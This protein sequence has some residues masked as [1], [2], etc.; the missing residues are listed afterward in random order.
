MTGAAW[1][2]GWRGVLLAVALVVPAHAQSSAGLATSFA[3]DEWLRA[4]T[5]I[6]L[7]IAAVPEAGDA[8]RI[9]L[10]IGGVDV[11]A[12]VTQNGRRI[13]YDPRILPLPAGESEIVAYGVASSGEWQ[14]LGRAGL[15]V[16]SAA[17]FERAA[18]DPHLSLDMASQLA[19]GHNTG[20]LAPSRATF[21][22]YSLQ[23]GLQTEHVRA[24]WSLRSQLNLHGV[25]NRTQALRF[26]EQAEAAPRLDLA[27]YLVVGAA[28]RSNISVGHV[29]TPSQRNLADGQARR[30]VRWDMRLAGMSAGLVASNATSVVGWANPLGLARDR[31]R[32]LLGRFGMDAL[33]GIP[34][35]VRLGGTLVHGSALPLSGY[36]GGGVLGAERSRGAGIDFEASD[37]SGRVRLSSSYAWSR[38]ED[39]GDPELVQGLELVPIGRTTRSARHLEVG[40]D[41][42][43]DLRLSGS[44]SG[45]LSATMRHERIDPLYRSVATFVQGD[46]E[47][48]ALDVTG[49][50]GA[51]NA[52]YSYGRSRDNLEAIP[53]VLTTLTRAQQAGV[54]LPFGALFGAAGSRWLPQL[55]WGHH[56]FHQFG[57]SV[58]VDGDF[59]ETHVPDQITTIRTASAQWSLGRLSGGYQ[60]EHST[61]DNRQ[62]GREDADFTRTAHTVAAAVQ[63]ATRLELGADAGFEEAL[64]HE[65][66][67]RS[68]VRR[69][70]VTGSLVLW[71]NARIAAAGSR[72][73]S[74]DP[75][76]EGASR[77]IDQ[78]RLE[79][80]QGVTLRRRG[81]G[82]SFRGQLFL[83]YGRQSGDLFGPAA[84][85]RPANWT[86]NSGVNLRLF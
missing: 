49:R 26:G 24:R 29:G 4:G 63:L 51:L 45:A 71:S 43:R 80:T 68:D 58:P 83:R 52:H 78:L 7:T 38:F 16:L 37:P 48:N 40:L 64:S 81:T 11:S 31:H 57:E 39:G 35:P 15:R 47:E 76:D 27:D 85:R 59:A 22:D 70:G 10:V 77:H 53:S 62:T 56:R 21:Q 54:A 9:A 74:T 41:A 75:F 32:L 6:E 42:V 46:R 72:T 14:E 2:G 12:L 23:S 66:D 55:G 19:E 3:A 61:Q 82:D 65:S 25:S 5:A 30:G 69:I 17:G 1:R 44:T 28:G 20:E 18:V 8:S 13:R 73:R 84:G 60:R 36:T 33:P 34:A 86:L 79:W 67:E 50:I